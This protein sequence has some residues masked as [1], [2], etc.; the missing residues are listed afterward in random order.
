[1]AP[2][3]SAQKPGW[4]EKGRLCFYGEKMNPIQILMPM[5]GLGRRFI[6]AGY[7]TPKPLIPVDG[8]PMFQKA[9]D[10]FSE[11]KDSI[12]IFVLRQD[13]ISEYQIDQQ[14]KEVLPRAKIAVL[15]QNTRGSVE[16]CLLA[17]DL[18]KDSLPIIVTDCDIYFQSKD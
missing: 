12:N 6:E 8:K 9:L 10:S 14:I 11:L 15:K 18:I 13:Q 5:G 17:K 16:T 3:H 2:R 7:D 1:M 4:P